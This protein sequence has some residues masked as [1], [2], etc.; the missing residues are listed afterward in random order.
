MITEPHIA[1]I[2]Y[3]VADFRE[4]AM[5]Y[6]VKNAHLK[7]GDGLDKLAEE[8]ATRITRNPEQFR[9]CVDA[10]ERA[11]REAEERRA[12]AE[13]ALSNKRER[14]LN[15]IRPL[16]YADMVSRKAPRPHHFK[17]VS[18]FLNDGS[19]YWKLDGKTGLIL[20]GKTG[21]GKTAS[22]WSLLESVTVERPEW[23]FDFVRSV[24]FVIIAKS[25][26]MSRES[27]EE[28]DEL[29]ERM[30]TVDFLV[31]DDLGSEKISES[32][33][34]VLFELLDTRT[35][36][37]RFTVITTNLSMNG[38]AGKFLQDKAKIM[39]R[40]EQFFVLVDFDKN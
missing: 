21:A 8:L 2:D 23:D 4:A 1:A 17:F 36:E 7:P 35:V 11:E 3:I 38:L 34:E 30:L 15:A 28:F 12:R 24:R 18:E 20:V 31:L 16:H 32:A 9:K 25:R 10:A 14:E 33:E 26:H 6:L 37:D 19:P 27:K 5:K 40:L 13:L 29:F 22:A 39:R